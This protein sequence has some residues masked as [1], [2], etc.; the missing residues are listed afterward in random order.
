MRRRGVA[1]RRTAGSRGR[2]D[3][4]RPDGGRHTGI[5]GGSPGGG[6]GAVVWPAGGPWF[7]ARGG[8]LGRGQ[9]RAARCGGEVHRRPWTSMGWTGTAEWVSGLAGPSATAAALT[10][11]RQQ[12]PAVT[13]GHDGA[14][15]LAGRAP[16]PLPIRGGQRCRRGGSPTVRPRVA[17]GS[18]SH[19]RLG[20][21][22]GSVR[23]CW[24]G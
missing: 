24:L 21:W 18:R 5:V 3:A 4:P 23:L 16:Q 10:I 6:D 2:C 20:R 1:V 11:A 8:A 22:K 7:A 12:R 17:G 14:G 15:E 19:R 9:R 13:L